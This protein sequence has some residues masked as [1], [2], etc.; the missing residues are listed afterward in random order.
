MHTLL[1]LTTMAMGC[2][3]CKT[4]RIESTCRR[5]QWAGGVRGMS[6]KCLPPATQ[7]L[8]HINSAY[9]TEPKGH[10]QSTWP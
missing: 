5:I 8:C 7:M 10:I 9:A 1:T 3:G 4:E 6:V 2:T